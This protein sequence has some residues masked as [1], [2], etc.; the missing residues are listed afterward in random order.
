M[1]ECFRC[2]AGLQN[3][4][5][6]GNFC[7][8]PLFAWRITS[9]VTI[10][11]FEVC[12]ACLP[13]FRPLLRFSTHMTTASPEAQLAPILGR[14]PSGLFILVVAGPQGVPT[15]M[16]AS[17]V[18]QA[19]FS[20]PQVTLAVN[21]ARWINEYLVPGTKVTLNQATKG[22][23]VLLRHFGKG[24]EPG[25][26]AFEG[27]ECITGSTGLPLLTAAMCSLEGHIEAKLSAGDHDIHLITLTNATAHRDPAEFEP[28]VHIRKNG[29]GY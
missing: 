15:G 28:W 3:H 5:T 6:H 19:S 2:F 20:P 22:D 16:L 27:L 13:R 7:P 9:F 23:S 14:V 18:Q 24:F 25:A 21:K 10:L 1:F 17:W 26:N 12:L 4:P 11:D 29:L 8:S